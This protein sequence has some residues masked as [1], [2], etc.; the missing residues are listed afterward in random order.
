M[1]VAVE[2]KIVQPNDQVEQAEI[3]TEENNPKT[4]RPEWLPEKFWDEDMGQ[5]RAESLANSYVE[6]EKRFGSDGLGLDKVPASA[7]EYEIKL[8]D[9][10]A[11]VDVEITT[12]LHK[13]GFTRDQAQLV[14]DL[15]VE[16][17]APVV[18]AMNNDVKGERQMGML[19][20]HFGGRERWAET[21]RQI[22]DW[23]NA[24]LTTET[25]DALSSSYDGIIVLHN[26]MGAKEPSVIGRAGSAPSG[27]SEGDLRQLMRDPRY[28]RERDP[29]V[30]AQV[31]GGF[32][33]LYPRA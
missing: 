31:R 17:L 29:D 23:G 15:G 21:A 2:E 12:R 10:D 3:K 13:A 33:K 5:V 6:L 27:T 28:W 20:N 22:N 9:A 24:N 7:D 30:V 26:M 16:Q 1:E 18:M 19:E 32:E 4:E 14:Y 11:P 25:F 8:G